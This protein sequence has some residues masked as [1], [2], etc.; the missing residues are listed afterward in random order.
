MV[1]VNNKLLDDFK[2]QVAISNFEEEY[3]NEQKKRTNVYPLKKYTEDRRYD[4]KKLKIAN[5]AAVLAV[6]VA[7]GCVTPTIYAKIKWNIEFNEY[8]E[9]MFESPRETID[10]AK[11]TGFADKIDE[12]YVVKDG[13]GIKLDS[14][15]LT[16]DC[17]DARVSFKFAEEKEVDSARFDF[18]YVIYDENKNVYGLQT[19]MHEDRT[20]EQDLTISTL[21]KLGVKYDPNAIYNLILNDS[22]T[23]ENVVTTENRTIV[24]DI[25][26]RAKDIFPKSQKIYIEFFDIGYL[27][28]DLEAI[29]TDFDQID[30]EDFVITEEEWIFERDTSEKFS[31]RETLELVLKDEIPDFRIEKCTLTESGMVLEFKSEEYMR[32]VGTVKEVD[33]KLMD[34]TF[35]MVTITDREGKQYENLGSGGT[36]N[37]T[38]K[39]NIDVGKKDFERKLFL[40]FTLD[41]KKY[42]SQLVEK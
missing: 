5:V 26:L 29:G 23:I 8:K 3:E 15:L 6:V 19:R 28:M 17:L 39:M 13:V 18:G 27:M 14:F 20:Q 12:D 25:T 40:N 36:E 37:G 21:E 2:K 10:Y 9:K 22:A 16:D 11:E 4:M 1:L 24:R 42:T 32:L 33:G 41:E 31:K 30:K 38:Y 35:N 34:P 7:I